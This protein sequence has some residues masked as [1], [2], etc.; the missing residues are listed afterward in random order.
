M[1]SSYSDSAYSLVAVRP[2]LDFVVLPLL[3]EV[4][5][6]DFV[7][8]HVRRDRLGRLRVVPSH[9]ADSYRIERS[10][11]ALEYKVERYKD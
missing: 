4:R 7:V 5:L 10:V 9:L 1:H 3:A 2:S 8:I 11:F 6:D